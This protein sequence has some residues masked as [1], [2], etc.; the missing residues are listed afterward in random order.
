VHNAK[1][2]SQ[3][4]ASIGENIAA[5]TEN[6]KKK[7]EGL[8]CELAKFKTQFLNTLSSF[9][10]WSATMERR[11]FSLLAMTF[12]MFFIQKI[13]EKTILWPQIHAHLAKFAVDPKL[14]PHLFFVSQ[15]L[16]PLHTDGLGLWEFFFLFFS[17]V[18]FFCCSCHKRQQDLDVGWLDVTISKSALQHGKTDITW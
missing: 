13:R 2:N 3:Y 12:L 14:F 5:W 9:Y 7:P 1:R 15:T 4:G 18:S 10:R 17:L 11:S 8:V 16:R 6:V